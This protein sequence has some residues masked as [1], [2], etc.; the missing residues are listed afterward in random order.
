MRPLLLCIVLIVHQ[1]CTNH[2]AEQEP[3][4]VRQSKFNLTTDYSEFTEKMEDGDTLMV[5]ADLSICASWHEEVNSFIKREGKVYIGSIN[6]GEFVN[7][8]EAILP[9][10]ENKACPSDS[11]SFEHLFK[12]L[13]DVRKEPDGHSPFRIMLTYRNDTIRF[14]SL[15]LMDAMRIVDHYTQIKRCLYPEVDLYQPDPISTTTN[16]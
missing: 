1:S 13:G 15:G 10:V 7:S 5:Y 2:I 9:L 6:K 14:N 3:I 4:S 8:T 11:L 12:K 16:L